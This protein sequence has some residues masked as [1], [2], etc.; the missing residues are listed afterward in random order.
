M[1]VPLDYAFADEAFRSEEPD[2]EFLQAINVDIDD[3]GRVVELGNIHQR[4]HDVESE[5]LL[6]QNSSHFMPL[7]G[8]QDLASDVGFNTEFAAIPPEGL[9]ERLRR[10][11]GRV[12]RYKLVCQRQRRQLR[13]DAASIR[14]LERE[15]I[16]LEE[17][18]EAEQMKQD[19]GIISKLRITGHGQGDGVGGD[20]NEARRRRDE[21]RR[22]L[23]SGVDLLGD[24]SVMG[25][26]EN[27]GRLRRSVLKVRCC[28]VLRVENVVDRL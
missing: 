14:R 9:A 25:S 11:M 28:N 6:Q 12:G 13:S 5:P 24:D 19:D 4:H 2:D 1:A 15:V 22:Q 7:E 23:F 3:Y 20:D 17:E 8:E 26:Q 18:V 27:S 21:A 10:V 16:R